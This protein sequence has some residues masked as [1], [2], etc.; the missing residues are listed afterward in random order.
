MNHSFPADV[1]DYAKTFAVL[2]VM[3]QSV[4]TIVM[5]TAANVS[6]EFLVGG[7]YELVKYA[8]P[9]FI[10]GTMYS[11]I[12]TNPGATMM[13]YPLYM[14]NRWHMLFV[15]SI[16]WTLAYLIL[17]PQLQQ[18]HPYT[19]LGTFCW[20]FINGNAAQHLWY[21]VMMLQFIIITPLFWYIA[22]WVNGNSHRGWLI[23][24]FTMIF[25]LCWHIMYKSQVFYG[26]HHQNWY[27]LD[28]VF[29]S[30]LIFAVLGTLL[31]CFHQQLFPVF[32]KFWWLI[33]IYWGLLYILVT[34]N[35]FMLGTPV[36]LTNAPYYLPSMLFY[37]IS[38]IL[39]ITALHLHHLRNS[40]HW[41]S[42][43][44]H[45]ADFAHRAYL[46]HV[47]WLYWIWQLGKHYWLMLNPGL[48]LII[49]YIL[50]V[51]CSFTSAFA[52]HKLWFKIKHHLPRRE[53]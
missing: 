3:L 52:F 14:R 34:R 28:R 5:R 37:N 4:L 50:T 18:G 43:C 21:N 45:I 48:L 16:W 6:Q 15:P 40:N 42:R 36:K 20:Q 13:N 8:A 7:I 12:R 38:A 10:F 1:G 27:L 31:W 19:N 41:L 24:V 33:L 9:M 17:T 53:K 47:F 46:S 25:Q 22:R 11:T 49:L 39:A 35:F 23:L 51:T 29:P 44:H 26:S 2:A 32:L 30:F